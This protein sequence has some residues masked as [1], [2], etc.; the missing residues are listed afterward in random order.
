MSLR[1]RRRSH[2]NSRYNNYSR[3]YSK[4]IYQNNSSSRYRITLGIDI[5]ILIK[6]HTGMTLEIS[7][8]EQDC[9]RAIEIVLQIGP[10]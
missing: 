10:M 9:V 3:D 2:S 7:V 5:V 4:D 6:I 8:V 1:G